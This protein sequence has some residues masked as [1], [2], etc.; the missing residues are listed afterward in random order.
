MSCSVRIWN[1]NI[2]RPMSCRTD[3]SISVLHLLPQLEIGGMGRAVVRLALRGLREGMRHSLLLFDKPFRSDECDINP[4]TVLTNYLSRRP[5]IDSSFARALARMLRVSQVKIVHAHNDTAIFYSALAITTGRLTKT[6]RLIGTF[7]TWPSHDTTGARLATRWAVGRADEIV[8]VSEELA[9]RLRR[10]G[11]T[12]RCSTIWNGVDFAEFSPLGS[13]HTWRN[14]LNIPEDAILVGHVG[15]FDPIKRHAD[16]FDAAEMLQNVNPPIYFVAAGNGPLFETFKKRV[17]TLRNVILLS[18]VKDVASLLRSL[19]IFVLCSSHEGAPQA[20]LE[21]MAC[22]RAIVATRVGGVPHILGADGAASAGR[23][24][25]P[26][27]PDMIAAE[28]LKLARD[29]ELR[30]RLSRLARQRAQTFSFD[31]EWARY[32]AL[33]S[34]PEPDVHKMR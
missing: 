25:P 27:R 28:L 20:L 7:R 30:E 13:G 22:A 9:D 24:I 26:F 12:S 1:D 14:E 6:T 16:L 32:A 2:L 4:G 34:A 31:H 10:R 17:L 8:A 33:Y 19:D 5:G 21:A 23:L 11:W 18:N 29:A 15:R 3:L